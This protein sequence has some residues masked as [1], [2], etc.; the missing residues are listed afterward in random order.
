MPTASHHGKCHNVLSISSFL[1][2][3]AKNLIQPQ[4]QIC[5]DSESSSSSKKLAEKVRALHAQDHGIYKTEH[6]AYKWKGAKISRFSV[7]LT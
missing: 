7:M 2:F 5:S 3:L 4:L 1:Q 6:T